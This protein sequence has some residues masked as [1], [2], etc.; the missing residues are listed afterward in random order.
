MVSRGRNMLEPPFCDR[1]YNGK[2]I[3]IPLLGRNPATGRQVNSAVIQ[4]L[5]RHLRVDH[6]SLPQLL[7]DFTTFSLP[8]CS[9]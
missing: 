8:A 5:W 9:A 1:S 4:G 2:I 6:R 3:R 7:F